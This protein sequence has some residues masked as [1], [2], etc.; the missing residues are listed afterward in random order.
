MITF[1]PYYSAYGAHQQL[2]QTSWAKM[3][4]VHLMPFA[5][6]KVLPRLKGESPYFVGEIQK[7]GRLKMGMR[8]FE[9]IANRS[10]LTIVAK[11]AYFISPNHIRF[12]LKPIPAGKVSEIPI[13]GEMMCTGV[14]YL[15]S[16]R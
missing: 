1:P 4:F 12:G 11:Q 10:A 13:L 7:L 14:V 3:P 15:L 5:L 16:K 6:S 2:L 8:R 9:E